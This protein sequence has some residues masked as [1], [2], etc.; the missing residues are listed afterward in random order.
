MI[1]LSADNGVIDNTIVIQTYT[2]LAREQYSI[3][4]RFAHLREIK[5]RKDAKHK[6]FCVKYNVTM[7]N[8]NRRKIE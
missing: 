4:P 6:I 2:K 1:G 7:L 5:S 8:T 3:F